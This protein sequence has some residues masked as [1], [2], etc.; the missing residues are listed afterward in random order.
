MRNTIYIGAKVH[1]C[2]I[3]KC[4][5]K[6]YHLS[7]RS[8]TRRFPANIQ[9]VGSWTPVHHTKMSFACVSIARSLPRRVTFS[10][11][12]APRTPTM[13]TG[14]GQLCEAVFISVKV[15]SKSLCLPLWHADSPNP[16]HESLRKMR[17]IIVNFPNPKVS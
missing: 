8:S 7:E 1:S 14:G 4:T 6:M 5:R 11:P 12:T 3:L 15:S 10:A 13:C 9:R 17:R 2:M 16:Q